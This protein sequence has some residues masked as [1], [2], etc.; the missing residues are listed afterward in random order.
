MNSATIKRKSSDNDENQ[1]SSNIIEDSMIADKN[2]IKKPK[3]TNLRSDNSTIVASDLLNTSSKSSLPRYN[4]K[5]STSIIPKVVKANTAIVNREKAAVSTLPPEIVS[6]GSSNS[7]AK[8]PTRSAAVSPKR[9][10]TASKQNALPNQTPRISSNPFLKRM[11]REVLNEINGNFFNNLFETHISTFH[12]EEKISNILGTLKIKAKW[13][14]K[15]KA[16]KQ[17]QVIKELKDLLVNFQD[18]IGSFKTQATSF[19]DKLV[20][21]IRDCYDQVVDDIQLLSTSQSNEKKTRKE[22]ETIAAEKSLLLQKLEDS[23]QEY[24]NQIN[25]LETNSLLATKENERL[26]EKLQELQCNSSKIKIQ[27]DEMLQEFKINQE[28]H[29][30]EVMKVH[31]LELTGL[32]SNHNLLQMQHVKLE[33][34]YEDVQQ[35]LATVSSTLHQKNSQQLDTSIQHEVLVRE[36]VRLLE[37]MKSLKDSLK[38]KE[39][40]MRSNMISHY[41]VLKQSMDE[42]NALWN[43][44]SQSNAKLSVVEEDRR[45]LTAQISQQKE[46]T[47]LLHRTVFTLN[48]QKVSLEAQICNLEEQSLNSKDLMIQ[49][50][51]E[52]NL[53][54]YFEVQNEQ[55]KRERIASTAQ[56]LAVQNELQKKLQ[57]VEQRLANC[58]QER[59]SSTEAMKCEISLLLEIRKEHEETI[60]GLK[61]EIASLHSVLKEKQQFTEKFQG[62]SVENARNLENILSEKDK[63]YILA[64]EELSFCKGELE[65][66]KSKLNDTVA[67]NEST[68]QEERKRIFDLEEKLQHSEQTRR[69]LFNVIQEL[70]GNIRVFARVRPFLPGDYPG[71]SLVYPEG[72]IVPRSDLNTL[73]IMR[74]LNVDNKKD[75]EEGFDFS[76]D[77]VFGPATGQEG[78]FKEVSEFVQSALDGYQVC[79]FSYGQTGSGKTHTMNGS[80]EGDMRGIIP[81]A[82]EQVALY[83]RELQ[84]KGWNYSME[85]SFIEI[86]NESIRD[87]LRMASVDSNGSIVKCSSANSFASGGL[88]QTCSETKHDIKKDSNGNYFVTDVNKLPIDP[89]DYNSITK[90]LEV[91]ATQRSVSGTLMNEASS[92]SHAIFTLHLHA[93]NAL[94]HIELN[95]SLNLVD[96]AGSERIDRSGVVG[97]ELKEAVAIN[98]SLSALADVFNA[99]S[100]KSSH[101]P[102]R[103][104]KLTYLLQPA[105]SG[106]GKTLMIVNLSP[107]EASYH[108]SLS[109]LRFAN[110]VS[111]CELGK[112]KRKLKELTAG[113]NNNNNLD[114]Q[115]KNLHKTSSLALPSA[116]PMGSLSMDQAK[117]LS[118]SLGAKTPTNI[119]L[120]TNSNKT[121]LKAASSSGCSTGSK[122]KGSTLNNSIVRKTSYV[123]VKTPMK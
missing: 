8:S 52:K 69:K 120:T 23:K 11:Q 121:V 75:K 25:H 41:D 58:V 47:T 53:K 92:R 28:K 33:Q 116:A 22:L 30:E 65:K 72:A 36:N 4:R 89:D 50:Q 32:K 61:E 94:Q 34:D 85:I 114:E 115:E 76:F 38:E 71:D 93:V 63:N 54:S 87:L 96:L 70:R 56:F 13:D 103:N 24:S 29:N 83:K 117:S 119:S 88:N 106:D 31:I 84:Q 14:I 104:S 110:Q 99:I 55:E 3:T 43:E 82:M 37:E 105:L 57:D 20:N 15:E 35:Q 73:K 79:L 27:Y 40:D 46:E 68:K 113:C 48:E 9:P 107:T 2:S 102:F 1:N 42:K 18:T 95:G 66:M 39:E 7:S 64:V 6:L 10:N 101:V 122:I 123:A 109:S 77:R 80:G 112:P 90:I 21:S 62:F 98:K 26:L 111:Q 60:Y 44:L 100:N 97:Q 74:P 118:H 81:R 78:I 86:Y 67:F 12:L 19:E 91:A 16:K 17:E 59:E 45:S 51:T 49:L 108:E 5:M